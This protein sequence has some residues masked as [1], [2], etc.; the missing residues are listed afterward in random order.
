MPQTDSLY[1]LFSWFWRRSLD[2]VAAI[3]DQAMPAE[4]A[5]PRASEEQHC[6]GDF[7]GLADPAGDRRIRVGVLA[8]VVAPKP[9]LEGRVGQAR[10][11]CVDTDA[12]G[13]VFDG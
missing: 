8:G 12:L 13:E 1:A 4:E 10:Q 11:H 3:D 9:I 6:I 5:R 2:G 7:L